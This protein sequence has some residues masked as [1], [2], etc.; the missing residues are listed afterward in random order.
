MKKV[1]AASWVY[2]TWI[3]LLNER[4]M[5]LSSYI[6][7]TLPGFLGIPEDPRDKLIQ[8][9]LNQ[10]VIRARIYYASE[11][12]ELMKEHKQEMK[13][14]PKNIELLNLG[15]KLVKTSGYPIFVKCLAK[16]EPDMDVLSIVTS[17]V[18][19]VSDKKYSDLDLWNQSLQWFSKYGAVS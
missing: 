8:D 7:R 10:V 19:Q 5:T 6:A 3:L 17:E 15:D 18:N 1:R 16:R 13:E 12:S 14:D 9:E 4:G 2:P 11:M